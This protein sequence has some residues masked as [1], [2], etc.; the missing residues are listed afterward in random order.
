MKFLEAWCVDQGTI[1]YILVA[2]RSTIQSQDFLN[3]SLLTIAIPIVR[4]E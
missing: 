1:D 3:D 2:I 4:Q